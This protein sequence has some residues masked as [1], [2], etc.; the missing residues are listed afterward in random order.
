MSPPAG[1]GTP[2]VLRHCHVK[3]GYIL[4]QLGYASNM[5]V[6]ILPEHLRHKAQQA[7]SKELTCSKPIFLNCALS[8]HIIRVQKAALHTDV[9]PLPF[10]RA[11]RARR[12]T[13]RSVP[14]NNRLILGRSAHTIAMAAA[15]A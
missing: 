2:Q 12:P 3:R 1:T 13:K 4:H 5:T 11:A 14:A 6:V 10:C 8:A 15:S 9:G 7:N